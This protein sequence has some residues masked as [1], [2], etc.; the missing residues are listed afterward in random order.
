MLFLENK[1]SCR[2]GMDH[3][4]GQMRRLGKY[5]HP[6]HQGWSLYG[7]VQSSPLHIS[8]LKVVEELQRLHQRRVHL[9]YCA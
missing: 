1:G 2:F 6:S 7:S 8:D 3:Q 5:S 9:H 4:K